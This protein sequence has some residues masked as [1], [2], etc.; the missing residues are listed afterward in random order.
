M[1]NKTI[2]LI[3]WIL[4]EKV[5]F[6][7]TQQIRFQNFKQSLSELKEGWQYTGISLPVVPKTDDEAERIK[8]RGEKSKEVMFKELK[9]QVGEALKLF[10]VIPS[11]KKL[12]SSWQ[13]GTLSRSTPKVNYQT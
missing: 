11:W 5:C 8:K 9:T 13:R 12:R 3:S 2:M 7:I 4:L 6:D 10:L 1:L